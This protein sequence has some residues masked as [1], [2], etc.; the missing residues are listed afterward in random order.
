VLHP[1][2]RVGELDVAFDSDARAV[3]FEQA[4]YGVPVRM[5]LISLLLGLDG[6][7]LEKFQ[8]GFREQPLPI[9]DQPLSMGLRCKN[10]NCISHDPMEA[11]Y[12]RN[13]FHIVK[14]RSG[15]KIRCVYCETDIDRFV[16]A[17]KK[18]KSY[19]SEPDY[20]VRANKTNLKDFVLFAEAEEARESGFH[21][22]RRSAAS[23]NSSGQLVKKSAIPGERQ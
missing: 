19:T 6:R 18:S 8:G 14:S 15:C 3:Y 4:A 5:A 17:N 21:S 13:K 1:L 12:V 22:K 20:L 2:P 7:Q 9:Y 10:A 16:V 11:P 23:H